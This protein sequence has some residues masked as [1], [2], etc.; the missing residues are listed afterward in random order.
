M[1][2]RCQRLQSVWVG[3]EQCQTLYN[4]NLRHLASG[5]EGG[6]YHG[7]DTERTSPYWP[8]AVANGVSTQNVLCAKDEA[9]KPWNKQCDRWKTKKRKAKLQQGR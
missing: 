2:R 3:K 1:V 9:L 8:G 7:L 4:V 5:I 6:A